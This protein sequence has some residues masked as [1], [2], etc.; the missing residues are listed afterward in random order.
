MI[1][2][3]DPITFQDKLP[4]EVDVVIIGAGI[5]GIS[6]AWFLSQSGIS[7]LV[8]EKGRVSAEQSSRNWGWVRQQ[9]RDAAEL[10]V[11]MES[12]RI[13]EAIAEEV[14]D[15]VG[16]QKTGVMYLARTK[17]ELANYEKW[18]NTAQL[19]Q[20]DSYILSATELKEKLGNSAK[21]WKG[22][23]ST[24][25][26]GR[27]EPF[28][29]VP[30]I[31]RKLQSE[32]VS[33][34]ENCAVRT[35]DIEGG[36]V[37]G[38][39]TENGRVK[40]QSVVCAG[41]AWS[42]AFLGNHGINLPQLTVRSTV[43]R[44]APAPNFYNGAAAGGRI[45]FRRRQDGGYTIAPGGYTEHY[46]CADTFKY[47]F[48]FLPALI[49]TASHLRLNF[50]DDLI[51][52]LLPRRKWS[53]DE[54]T[55]FEKNRILNPDPSPSAIKRMRQGLKKHVSELADVP[56]VETW[57]G[58]IDT[59][60][61]VVPVMDSISEYPGLFLATGFSGHGFG[62]GPAAGKIMSELVQGIKP[63]HDMK[64]FRLSRFSDGSPMNP[65]PGL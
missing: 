32:G 10:P 63:G 24:P 57:A 18:I 45:A 41:G 30:A 51:R 19:H 44:S 43:A 53:S 12:A 21:H 23:L 15:E 46:P 60:P 13:W 16:Y 6:T 37:K 42:T 8:C 29:A 33:I 48:K 38:V 5:I 2:I 62:I 3:N 50:G 61:D 59:T 47:M 26:D 56:F 22:G 31:A 17:K 7:V 65:G 55:L 27:A 52:R 9:G 25:S 54:V 58:M 1:T 14:G 4:S 64:R 40:A 35:L 49:Q 20:L 11:M 36:I 39:V 34:R 28:T